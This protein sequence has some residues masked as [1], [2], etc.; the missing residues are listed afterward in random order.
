MENVSTTPEDKHDII[1]VLRTSQQHHVMLGMIADQ[2]ANIILGS[3]LIFITV[4]QGIL[5]KNEL[6]NIPIWMLTIAYTLAAIF[7]L[8]VITPRFR[9]KKSESGVKYG[10]LLFFGGFAKLSQDEFITELS[11]KL[12]SN[13][14]AHEMLM[15]DIYQIGQVLNK[16]YTNLRFSYGILAF[17]VFVS[18]VAF[19]MVRFF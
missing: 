10:N 1:Y 11:S 8:L 18:F 17:G 19:S 6:L 5:D 4:T 7:S 9:D 16:K 14:A 12:Q 15:Q 3:Y 13:Q 2:K